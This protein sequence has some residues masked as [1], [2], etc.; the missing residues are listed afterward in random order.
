MEIL[1]NPC[2]AELFDLVIIDG[3]NFINKF[4]LS[5]YNI[6]RKVM[7][8]DDLAKTRVD[9][10]II[11]DQTPSRQSLEYKNLVPKNCE[12]LTGSKYIFL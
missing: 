9:C 8:I 4:Q 12:I 10:D 6:A 7:V 5:I 1:L 11:L 3:Y 2:K